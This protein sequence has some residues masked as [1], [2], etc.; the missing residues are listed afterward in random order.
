MEAPADAPPRP[1][2]LALGG[3]YKTDLE[4]W[5]AAHEGRRQKARLLRFVIIGGGFAALAVWLYIVLTG[6]WSELWLFVMFVVGMIIVVVG[7]IPI[8]RLQS[9]VKKFVMEKLP[10]F[11]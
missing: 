8:S 3:F 5:L 1:E 7:H 9:D 2:F 4:P 11:F 6:D 10:R